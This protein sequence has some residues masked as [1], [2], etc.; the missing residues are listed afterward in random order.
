[1]ILSPNRTHF[2]G[3]CAGT[4]RELFFA[5]FRI[6]ADALRELLGEDWSDEM[7]AAWR[8]LISEIEDEIAE[9][10]I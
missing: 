4:P 6:I 9:S 10:G 1:M 5:F 2:G 8:A 7:G 3:S